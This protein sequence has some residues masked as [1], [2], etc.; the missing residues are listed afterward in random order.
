MIK[1][2][3][4]PSRIGSYYFFN[5]RVLG[6]ELNATCV[7]ATLLYYSGYK[8]VVEN[9]MNITLLDQNQASVINAIKKISSSIGKYDEVVTSLISST[10]VFK[11]LTLPF[12]GREKIKMIVGYEVEPLLPFPLDEAIIDFIITDENKEKSQTTILV[13]AA[14]QIDLDNH[15]AYFEKAGIKLDNV[16][17]DMFALYDFYRHGM[18]IT[19]AYTSVLLVDFSI[20]AIRMLYVQK[21]ILK[22]VRLIP[23]GLATMMKKADERTL[24]IAQDQTIDDIL[25][26]SVQENNDII[27]N[28]MAQKVIID[29]CKQIMLSVSFFQKQIK[30]FTMPSKIVCL[31]AGTGIPFFTENALVHCQIPIEILDVKKILM[32]NDI[33]IQKKVKVDSQHCASLVIALSSTHYGDVNFLAQK[34]AAMNHSLLKK[35]LWVLFVISLV[36]IAGIL[37]ASRYQL[38]IWDTAY[39]KSKKEVT[40]A[41]KDVMDVETKGVKRVS[42]MVSSAQ[43]KLEQAK[44]VCFSFSPSNHSFLHY[45]QDLSEKIDRDSL[46]LDLKKLSLH[47]KEVVLQGSVKNFD[48]LTIFEEELMELK[49][50]TIIEKP[51]G[52]LTFTVKLQALQDQDKK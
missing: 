27:H 34:Q 22:S 43:S 12:I 19:Q 36:T 17:L 8:V 3:F 30:N 1:D 2:I 46:G 11:E 32:R 37:L 4:V 15:H 18:Y 20:D 7:Q 5:K 14:R 41:L 29:F 25:D 38:A 39:N 10:V 16:T 21:G 33:S 35:Q 26:E 52:E 23:Y 49:N 50:F 45:L 24:S 31:G 51:A 48:A 42:D 6:F 40:T 13:A 28:E 44:K 9:S 47:D